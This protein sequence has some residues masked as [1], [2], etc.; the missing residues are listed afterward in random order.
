[1]LSCFGHT[2]DPRRAL[3]SIFLL[4]ALFHLDFTGRPR[5]IPKPPARNIQSGTDLEEMAP[6]HPEEAVFLHTFL[7]RPKGKARGSQ[8]PAGRRPIFWGSVWPPRLGHG[9]DVWGE[10]RPWATKSVAKCRAMRSCQAG[11]SCFETPLWLVSKGNQ[12]G[13][14]AVW[15]LR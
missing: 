2:H 1:M 12:E 11:V 15:G 3:S 8:R 4:V 10:R 13:L 5:T 6:T 7:Q 9:Q 14:Y